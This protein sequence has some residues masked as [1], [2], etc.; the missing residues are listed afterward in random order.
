MP[1]LRRRQI[2]S[3]IRPLSRAVFRAGL[4]A[5]GVSL[6]LRG[7]AS[8][9]HWPGAGICYFAPNF[10]SLVRFMAGVTEARAEPV[11]R[12]NS[13]GPA[14]QGARRHSEALPGR[15]L[16]E[17]GVGAPLLRSK[18]WRV[19]ANLWREPT[20][21]TRGRKRQRSGDGSA[22][23]FG[24]LVKLANGITVALR[25]PSRLAAQNRKK[26]QAVKGAKCLAKRN[27]HRR[28]FASACM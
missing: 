13:Q 10:C 21:P 18:V 1:S 24:A 22:A 7:S 8:W 28:R 17:T 14:K 9:S 16:D 23:P 15:V 27:P 12:C 2:S 11:V 19:R 5:C 20:S 4:A 3:G 25:S 26:R 6:F